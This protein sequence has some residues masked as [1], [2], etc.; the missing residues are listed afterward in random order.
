MFLIVYIADINS[1]YIFCRRIKARLKRITQ[2]NS[3]MSLKYI[4]EIA[5]GCGLFLKAVMF[6]PQAV[7]V[8]KAKASKELSLL[9][10]LSLNI[11][12][13][14]TVLHGY[15]NRDYLLMFGVLLS[16]LF[17]GAVTFMII[18]YRA[19]SVQVTGSHPTRSDDLGDP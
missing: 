4:V 1:D 16:L 19:K 15:Y 8:Y 2:E 12:Q 9:T 5:F 7:R 10:F 17:C 11:M 18:L 6:I 3:T 13:L 14:L